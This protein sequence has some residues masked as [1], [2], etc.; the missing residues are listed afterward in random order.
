MTNYIGD[1]LIPHIEEVHNIMIVSPISIKMS[2][3]ESHP[4]NFVTNMPVFLQEAFKTKIFMAQFINEAF[5][6]LN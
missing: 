3:S 2:P 5:C 1:I 6:R 4:R